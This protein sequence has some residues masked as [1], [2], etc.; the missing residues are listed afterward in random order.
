VQF[1][2]VCVCVRMLHHEIEWRQEDETLHILDHGC[3]WMFRSVAL[4]VCMYLFHLHQSLLH[5]IEVSCYTYKSKF[6]IYTSVYNRL[7]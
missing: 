7:Q 3:N 6:T 4:Y 1:F 5:D 2:F